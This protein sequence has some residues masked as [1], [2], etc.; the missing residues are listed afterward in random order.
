[1]SFISVE[2]QSKALSESYSNGLLAQLDTQLE[3]I[4]DRYLAFFQER[5]SIEAAY[6]DSLRKLHRK[7]KA[8]DV[9]FDPRTEPTTTRA[10]WD[11]I[12]DNLEREANIQQTFVD[13]LDNDVIKPLV[14]LK[15]RED[16]TRKRIEEDLKR[17]AANY[18]NYAELTISRLQ[19]EY[20][21]R[22]HPRFEGNVPTSSLGRREVPRTVEPAKSEA[23]FDDDCRWAVSHLNTLRLQRAENLGDGYDSLEELVYSTTVKDVLVKYMDGMTTAQRNHLATS[24]RAEV[25]QALDS[26]DTSILR[27]S[28]RRALRFSIPPFTIYR[29]YHPGAHSDSLFGVP[30]VDATTNEDNIPRVIRMCIEEVEKRGLY[31]KK[32]Y[33]LGSPIDPE[34]RQ[35]SGIRLND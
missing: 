16:Q 2:P 20:F 26:A 18:A 10:G 35:A 30:L 32:I 34:V 1:M 13:I 22:Y 23:A 25:E 9:S 21:K 12:R 14:S 5:R 8:V 17:S 27:V 19:K 31:T 28:F 4:S 15:E 7:A 3:I 33:S 24:T 11:K 6:I 29:N